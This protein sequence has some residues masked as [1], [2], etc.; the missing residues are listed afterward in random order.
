MSAIIVYVLTETVPA[1]MIAIARLAAGSTLFDMT[2]WYSPNSSWEFIL[3]DTTTVT[4]SASTTESKTLSATRVCLT[5]VVFKWILVFSKEVG[6]RSRVTFTGDTEYIFCENEV[7]CPS[8]AATLRSPSRRTG[9]AETNII[10]ML[11]KKI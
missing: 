4:P 3:N 6:W 11:L 5:S 2:S 8:R 7:K 10:K 1:E 9:G